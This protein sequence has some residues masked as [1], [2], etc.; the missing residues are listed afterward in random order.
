MPVITQVCTKCKV[1]KP[2]SEFSDESTTGY[3]AFRKVESDE[4][5]PGDTYLWAPKGCGSQ[6]GYLTLV[7]DWEPEDIDAVFDDE[8]TDFWKAFDLMEDRV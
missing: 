2:P 1:G 4:L 5:E 7:V 8:N 6:P 3:Y